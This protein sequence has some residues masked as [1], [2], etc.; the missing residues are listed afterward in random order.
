MAALIVGGAPDLAKMKETML[1]YGLVPIPT[2]LV[3]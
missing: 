1:R 2:A 3:H